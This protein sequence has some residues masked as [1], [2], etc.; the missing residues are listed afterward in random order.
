MKTLGN[1][2]AFESK[3]ILHYY[4]EVL[5][6]NVCEKIIIMFIKKINKKPD[7]LGCFASQIDTEIAGPLLVYENPAVLM[8]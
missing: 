3:T 6:P 4:N 1:F 8:P 7:N 2:C 5:L